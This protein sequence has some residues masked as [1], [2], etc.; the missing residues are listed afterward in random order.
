MVLCVSV[1]T[2]GMSVLYAR[3]GGG[4]RGCKGSR[5]MVLLYM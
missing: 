4:S 5:C 1:V 3:T 2:R